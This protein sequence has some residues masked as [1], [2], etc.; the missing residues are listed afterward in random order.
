MGLISGGTGFPRVDAVIASAEQTLDWGEANTASECYLY[1]VR[2]AMNLN[3]FEPFTPEQTALNDYLA[4]RHA[5]KRLCDYAWRL[6]AQ[7]VT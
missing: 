3:V 6:F 7:S 2:S 5:G 1:Q 4:A